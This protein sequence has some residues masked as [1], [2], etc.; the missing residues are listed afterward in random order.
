MCG[1]RREATRTS[2]ELGREGEGRRVGGGRGRGLD[3]AG[4][5]GWASGAL[6]LLRPKSVLRP[7]AGPRSPWR[8]LPL[9]SPCTAFWPLLLPHFQGDLTWDVGNRPC[10]WTGELVPLGL[11]PGWSRGSS[12]PLPRPTLRPC[13]SECTL[14]PGLPAALGLRGSRS[15]GERLGKGRRTRTVRPQVPWAGLRVRRCGEVPAPRRNCTEGPGA[16]PRGHCDVLL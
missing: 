10:A 4:R 8:A 13:T 2:E 9:G 12:C 3:R 15:V 7:A 1:R 14:G 5:G 16:G 6:P 11:D